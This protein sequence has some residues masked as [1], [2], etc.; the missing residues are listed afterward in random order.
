MVTDIGDAQ[1]S[2]SSTKQAIRI[3]LAEVVKTNHSTEEVGRATSLV[4]RRN[5]AVPLTTVAMKNL[6]DQ[7]VVGAVEVMRGEEAEVVAVSTTR[8]GAR[9][10]TTGEE[11]GRC[12]R[13]TT[14]MTATTGENVVVLTEIITAV[15][16]FLDSKR[17]C[18]KGRKV[19][20][21]IT[22]YYIVGKMIYQLS[23]VAKSV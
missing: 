22:D 23:F 11:A 10:L 16:R 1:F 19:V 9:I 15:D 13:T 14:T 20:Q 7:E 17:V 3:S 4:T 8:G 12:I 2:L 21:L 5:G 18:I 6:I